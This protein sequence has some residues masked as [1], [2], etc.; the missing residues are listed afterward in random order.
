VNA[1]RRFPFIEVF[2]VVMAV[3]ALSFVTYQNGQKNQ[4]AAGSYDSY[5]SYDA[6]SGG[7]RAWYEL[8]EREGVRVA[9]FERRPAFIDSSIDVYVISSDTY[10]MMARAQTG[11]DAESFT[12]GDW[13][14]IAKWVKAGG[15][16]VWLADGVSVSQ[17]INAPPIS[18]SG[19]SRD[20]AVSVAPSPLTAGV[21][22]VSGTSRLRAK[23]DAMSSAAPL[24][25]DDTGAVVTSY[26]SGR[27]A[28]T[29]VTDETLFENSRLDKADNARLAYDL[30]TTGL[31][32]RGSVAFDEWSHGY[33][34]GD[35]WW[36]VLPRQ[37]Q[38]A[39]IAIAGALVLLGVGTA[40]R[41]GP[42]VDPPAET[43]RTSAEYLASMATLYERGRGIRIAV[44]ELADAC[45]REVAGSLGL[46][47]SATA[48][49][50]AARL[51]DDE[52][53]GSSAAA[54]MELD[55]LRSFAYPHDPDLLRAAQLC[56][57]L[58][59]DLSPHGRFGFRRRASAS[60]RTA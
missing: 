33:V 44:E 50:I 40:F 36:S 47:E 15:H 5:S 8:L 38:V 21:R 56:Y 2:I 60:R 58:R 43:G 27:G 11:A 7:Y 1:R 41:F 12:D 32:T 28:V 51:G 16:L 24:V 10:A 14:A 22:A 52:I 23:F 18:T 31:T 4:A 57:F 9:R 17:S 26:R 34:A 54:V 48:R 3:G 35:D 6:A 37:F 55:R 13:D 19:P 20:E 25:A 46:A 53:P 42:T 39:L 49:S 59:K 45:L 30:A 29:I